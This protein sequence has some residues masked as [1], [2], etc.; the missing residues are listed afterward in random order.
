M[1]LNASEVAYPLAKLS[2][3]SQKLARDCAAP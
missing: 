1:P 2:E 3:T